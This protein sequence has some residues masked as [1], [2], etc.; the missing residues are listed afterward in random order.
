MKRYVKP[1]NLTTIELVIELEIDKSLESVPAEDF[2]DYPKTLKEKISDFKLSLLNDIIASVDN[3]I[4]YYRFPIVKKGPAGNSYSYYIRFTPVT[5][6]GKQ[7]APVEIV[8]RISSHYSKAAEGSAD[9]PKVRVVQFVLGNESFEDSF[10]LIDRAAYI[11]EQ[12]Y[13]GN[14]DAITEYKE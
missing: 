9:S 11:C 10:A 1:K 2:L 6:E 5:T 14:K 8:F 13:L 12:L 7:L 3:S 4:R